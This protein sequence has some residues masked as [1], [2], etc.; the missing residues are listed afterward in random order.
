VIARSPGSTGV[1]T[2]GCRQPPKNLQVIEKLHETKGNTNVAEIT[3]LA[4][5]LVQR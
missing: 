3:E 1:A 5:F 2:G 4:P